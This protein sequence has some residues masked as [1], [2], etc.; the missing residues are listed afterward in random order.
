MDYKAHP[1][2]GGIVPPAALPKAPIPNGQVNP[3]GELC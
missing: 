3:Q 1:K 2:N